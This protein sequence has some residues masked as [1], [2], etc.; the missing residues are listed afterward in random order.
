MSCFTIIDILKWGPL[1]NMRWKAL[2]NCM[3]SLY[4]NYHNLYI[5]S[6]LTQ[7]KSTFLSKWYLIFQINY[8]VLLLRLNQCL[9]QL[10]RRQRMVLSLFLG[11]AK[12]VWQYS[13]VTKDTNWVW[14]SHS[15]A[16]LTE[17][18]R[19]GTL[20]NV[21]KYQKRLLCQPLSSYPRDPLNYTPSTDPSWQLC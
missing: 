12:G 19:V 21:V 14:M 15:R 16:S 5:L 4:V 13:F 3:Y 6:V 7:M 8:F 9:A 2:E 17:R 18:G 20:P 11:T 10:C 1:I